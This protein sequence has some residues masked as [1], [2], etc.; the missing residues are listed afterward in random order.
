MNDK[1]TFRRK[2]TLDYVNNK[3]FS[4]AVAVHARGV[5][6]DIKEGTEPRAITSYIGLCLFKIANGLSRSPNFV[7]YPFREDMVMDAVENC[8]RVIDGF[9]P[10]APTRTGTPN[11]FGYFTQ[12]CYFC[13]LRRIAKEKRQLEIKQRLIDNM[14]VDMFA[15]FGTDDLTAIGETIIE[16]MRNKNSFYE[17]D[18]FAEDPPEK[19]HPDELPKKRGRPA[20]KAVE[21]G[22]LNDFFASQSI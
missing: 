17:D 12:I 9:D 15:E 22:P 11:A 18:S 1:K 10:D 13:F 16:R 6:A 21:C 2:D 20:K 5:A 3:E 4:D 7:N 8:I 14:S 19:D